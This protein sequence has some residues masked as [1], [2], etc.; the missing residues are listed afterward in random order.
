[1]KRRVYKKSRTAGIS[2]PIKFIKA[3]NLELNELANVDLI[4]GKIVITKII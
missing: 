3:L 4:D 1:M 2:I